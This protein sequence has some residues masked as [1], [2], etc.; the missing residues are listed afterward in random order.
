VPYLCVRGP[1]DYVQRQSS[2]TSRPSNTTPEVTSSQARRK[3]EDDDKK[4]IEVEN[5]TAGRR[6][7][8]LPRDLRDVRARPELAGDRTN[9]GIAGP[10]AVPDDG[11]L[12]RGA[13]LW[14]NVLTDGMVKDLNTGLIWEVKVECHPTPCGGLH[15]V[16]NA[17]P[18]SGDGSTDTIWDWLDDINAEGGAGYAGHHD[19]RIPNLR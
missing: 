17:Y 15:D 19:W 7:A 2:S 12:Q 10:V 6:T 4:Q 13:T 3:E 16:S 8:G 5:S 18:W 14:Y 11:T 9:D 1:P